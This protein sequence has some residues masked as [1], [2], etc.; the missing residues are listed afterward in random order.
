[1]DLQKLLARIIEEAQ[2]MWQFRWIGLLCAWLIASAGW[3]TVRMMPD[4]YHAGACV[5]VNTESVLKPLLQG[6]TVPTDPRDQ[7]KLMARALLS[8]PHLEAVAKETGLDARAGSPAEHERLLQRLG[9][10]ILIDRPMQADEEQVYTI[11]YEDHDPKMAKAV[12]QTLLDDF[13]SESRT[14]DLTESAEAGDFL[15]TQLKQYEKRL[16][17]AEERL[18]AFKTKNLGLLEGDGGFYARFQAARAEAGELQSQ[19]NSLTNKRNELARQLAGQS[20]A[21]SGV[22]PLRSSSV[23]GPIA[24]LEA[25]ITRLQLR[26][27]DKHPDVLR[28]RQTLDDLYKIREEELKAKAAGGPEAAARRSVD[29]VSQ[30]I[31]IALSSTDADLAAL[32]SQLAQKNAEVTYLR[33]MASTIPEVEAQLAR[34]NRD[35]TVVKTEYETLLQ[36]LESS[37]MNQEVQADNKD[38]SFRVMDPPRLPL[39][40]SSP[41]RLALNTLV[42]LGALGAG[43]LL[44]FALS[45]RDPTFFSSAALNEAAGVPVYGQVSVVSAGA[46]AARSWR[47]EIVA[48]ALLAAYVLVLLVSRVHIA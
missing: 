34:L 28:A 32:R 46:V 7:V 11:S 29:P 8:R 33:G 20:S 4:T 10:T 6:L 23:D 30:G 44:A 18:A 43:L 25:E 5:Y 35:Y 19:I 31:K 15:R 12:V 41:N 3:L 24:N 22:D 16:T 38:V 36:R 47:F 48:G 37:R 40:P 13:I 45:Q 21:T 2:R 39:A 42:L 17:E 14:S 26:F 9:R 1:M 27:T